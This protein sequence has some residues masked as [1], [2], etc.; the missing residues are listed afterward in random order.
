MKEISFFRDS[1]Y[2]GKQLNT[3]VF[4][5]EEGSPKAVIVLLHGLAEH[6]GRYRRFAECLTKEGFALC[7]HDH[8]GHGAAVPEEE[9]GFFREKNGW[10]TVCRDG[11]SLVKAMRKDYP[12]SPIILMGHSMGSFMARTIYLRGLVPIDGLILSGTGNMSGAIVTGGKLVGKWIALWRGKD[13]VSPMLT[14]LALGAYEKPFKGEG[15]NAWISSQAEEI[16]RYNADP[17]CGFPVKIGMFLDMFDG[18]SY[19][20]NKKNIR[21][22]DKS[23][24]ILFVS[25]KEDPVGDMGKG[26][27]TA[28]RAFCE[29]GVQDVSMML[30]DGCRHEILNDT[31][32]EQV[33]RDILTWL[34]E[35][36]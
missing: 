33:E 2:E 25:G 8:L 5:P 31:C 13:K 15:K 18:L 27:T 11:A 6:F 12:D 1:R 19:I 7:G 34:S 36:I 22:A 16:A 17:L 26:V 20:F 29:A 30:Y 4:L 14:S 32:R 10:E 24:P 3:T 35:R 23:V 9:R 28:Y 21:L